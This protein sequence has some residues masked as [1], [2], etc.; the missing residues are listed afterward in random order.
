[1]QGHKTWDRK[2]IHTGRFSDI[3]SH[4]FP[5][6]P[7]PAG[8]PLHHEGTQEHDAETPDPAPESQHS[9]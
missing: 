1:M 2:A 5:V 3:Q 4:L 6:I 9:P 7:L 8:G